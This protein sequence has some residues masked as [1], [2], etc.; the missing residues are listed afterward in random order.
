[1]GNQLSPIL[2]DIAVTC[3]E[4]VWQKT[5]SVWLQNHHMTQFFYR[6]V[7]NRMAI[8]PKAHLIH[9]CMQQF[10]SH[11]FYQAPVMLEDVGS[12][13]LLGCSIDI[14]NRTCE[15]VVPNAE[16]QFRSIRSAG[17]ERLN[18]SGLRS[19]AALAARLSHPRSAKHEALSN[20]LDA[21]VQQG[22]SKTQ[23][24]QCLKRWW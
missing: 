20:L 3:T 14:Q 9:Q 22:Y 8:F 10:C 24:N 5:Y 13:V 6:Y 4:Q 18:L 2:C 11:Q 16:W 23:V 19:R 12:S 7:D 17:S 21:Y 1:M 15:Y